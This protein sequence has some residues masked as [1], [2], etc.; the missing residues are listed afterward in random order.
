MMDAIGDVKGIRKL[1][2]K[3]QYF[4]K[5]YLIFSRYHEVFFQALLRGSF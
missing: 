4:L 1:E 5:D 2:S 3:A